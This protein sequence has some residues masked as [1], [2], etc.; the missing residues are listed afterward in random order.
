MP[1]R[2]GVIHSSFGGSSGARAT[3]PCSPLRKRSIAHASGC[4]SERWQRRSTLVYET[5][6]LGW[7]EW[8]GGVSVMS[9]AGWWRE[10]ATARVVGPAANPDLPV[11][12]RRRLLKRNKFGAAHDPAFRGHGYLVGRLAVIVAATP[13]AGWISITATIDPRIMSKRLRSLRNHPN[14][15]DPK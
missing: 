14:E 10:Y 13:L 1:H 5:C 12:A 7:V 11:R 4:H 9:R 3:L 8:N 6:D 2:S 15:R